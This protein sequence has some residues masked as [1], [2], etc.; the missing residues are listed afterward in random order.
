MSWIHVRHLADQG[1]LPIG[2]L[3]ADGNVIRR[4][5]CQF[6]SETGEVESFVYDTSGKNVIEDGDA[7]RRLETYPA[8]LTWMSITKEEAARHKLRYLDLEGKWHG[9]VLRPRRTPRR[10]T[11]SDCWT[12]GDV[13]KEDVLCLRR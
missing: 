13:P 1:L 2:I 11:D 3:D 8:P 9:R 10:H 7:K 12:D 4:G 6:N 5:V